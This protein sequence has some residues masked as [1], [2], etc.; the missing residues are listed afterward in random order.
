ME[1]RLTT[2][3][4]IT[5]PLAPRY[6]VIIRDPTVGEVTS[7]FRLGDH[8]FALGISTLLTSGYFYSSHL[9]KPSTIAWGAFIL[10]TMYVLSGERV[11][12]RLRGVKENKK[13]C[14]KYGIDFTENITPYNL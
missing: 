14:A 9:H 11:S 8:F 10:P 13:D 4:I 3:S 1:N 5:R 7:N 12:Q 2:S 6:P